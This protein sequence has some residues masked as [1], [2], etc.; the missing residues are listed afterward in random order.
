MNIPKLA[1]ENYHIVCTV[2]AILLVASIINFNITQRTEFP[3]IDAPTI[4]VIAVIA[5]T[6]VENIETNFLTPLE[7]GLFELD[8]V[9]DIRS[10]I[11]GNIVVIS[12]ELTHGVDLEKK[13]TETKN[14]VNFK[15]KDLPENLIDLNVYKSSTNS[16]SILN[17]A[18]VHDQLN[19]EIIEE[20]ASRLQKTLR[21]VK[22]VKSVKLDAFP[23]KEIQIKIDLQKLYDSGFTFNEIEQILRTNNAYNPGGALDLSTKRINVIT[24]GGYDDINELKETFLKSSNGR[25]IHLKDI[26]E[27]G[28]NS[29]KEKWLSRYNGQESALVHVYQHNNVDVIDVTNRIK[30]TLNDYAFNADIQL[31]YVYTQADEVSGQ[32]NM[33]FK[34]LIQG[35]ILVCVI[36]FI[37]LGSRSALIIGI[38]IPLASF[39]G[40]MFTNLCGF[41][42]NQIT[43]VGMVVSLGLLVDNSI[44]IVEN[45]E[46]LL[47]EGQ[48]IFDACVNGV[49]QLLYSMT[50]STMTTMA[51]FIPI[52]FMP[53]VTGDF[54]KPMPV[55]VLFTMF[56]SLVI[57]ITL[58]PV[59]CYHFLDKEKPKPLFGLIKNTEAKYYQFLDLVLA[60]QRKSLGLILGVFV[61]SLLIFPKVGVSFFP[62]ADKKYFIVSV[63]TEKGKNLNYTD[64]VVRKVEK[65]LNEKEEINAYTSSVGHGNPSIFYNFSTVNYS[66]TYGE[67]F[68]ETK[69]DDKKEFNAFVKSLREE[70]K[71]ISQANINIKEFSQG[72]VAKHPLEVIVTG[73]NLEKLKQYNKAIVEKMENVEGILNIENSIASKILDIDFNIIEKEAAIHGVQEGVVKKEITNIFDGGLV[74]TMT[75]EDNNILNI[76]MN[77]ELPEQDKLD[78]INN[79]RVR[80]NS[81]QLITLDKL[82]DMR[83]SS[84]IN[85]L[86]HINLDRVSNIAADIKDDK[87]LDQILANLKTELNTL[88]WEPGYSFY[89][90]GDFENR[91][92]SFGQL[93]YAV[94]IA[95]MIILSILIAQYKSLIIPMI[96]LSILP[97]TIT[98][99]IFA[100]LLTGQSFSFTA[101]IGLIS[102]VG[103]C[104]ND[105]IILV[106]FSY[107]LFQK[108]IPAKQ[109]VLEGARIRLIPILMTS[110]TT[111]LGLVFLALN[112]GSLWMPMATTIIGG[113]IGTT[114]F[115]LVLVPILFVYVSRFITIVQV[116]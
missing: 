50:S 116:K 62:K 87:E 111:I 58:A 71:S 24:S 45:I 32:I 18:L 96:I 44:A 112:G 39:I 26:A 98:G 88:E 3:V 31:Q 72:L 43:I 2:F 81:G 99:S 108:G 107:K 42:L 7:E 38:F 51:V 1:I 68:I 29:E 8:D 73:N 77:Y 109:A 36:L 113:L 70:I 54:I 95:V 27:I 59:L 110:V 9:E 75:D 106:D 6:N 115:V 64:E 49:N 52:I 66:P 25:F 65:L 61:L 16:F 34:N 22:G 80:N 104:I 4:A 35:L 101:F 37:V 84:S 76:K 55:V 92:K 90:K 17:L 67:I 102:L 60:N 21:Q 69:L 91:D 57:A 63:Q 56:I 48:D 13:L 85:Q 100:L 105:S 86:S 74:G 11:T 94:I 14:I 41:G 28:F 19:P 33:F 23:Q 82:V 12:I 93:G 15:R 79:I 78:A 20:E 40:L 30:N 103:I 10:D 47:A 5:P 114:F 53:D 46:R 89:F 97:L 83:L